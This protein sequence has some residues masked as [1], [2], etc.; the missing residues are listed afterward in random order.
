MYLKLILCYVKKENQPEFTER[1][2]AWNAIS[3]VEGLIFQLGGWN[4]PEGEIALKLALWENEE[5]YGEFHRN[6]HDAMAQKAGHQHL[7]YKIETAFFHLLPNEHPGRNLREVIGNSSFLRVADCRVHPEHA[8]H[9]L[10]VQQHVWIPAMQQDGHMQGGFFSRHATEENRFLVASF[11]TDR[12]GH[13][14][15]ATRSVPLLR[16]KTNVKETISELKGYHVNLLPE[17]KA[18]GAAI[19][20]CSTGF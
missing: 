1:Q 16:E 2:A 14:G 19:G 6:I 13:E 7:Y 11:W 9:F 12:E 20:S 17:W 3:E 18:T 15:Y 5:L 4:T 8:D 10:K